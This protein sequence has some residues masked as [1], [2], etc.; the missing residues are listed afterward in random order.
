MPWRWQSRPSP[1][2]REAINPVRHH[3]RYHLGYISLHRAELVIERLQ[4]AAE[5]LALARARLG[6]RLRGVS[7]GRVADVSW[8]RLV[9]RRRPAPSGPTRAS[10]PTG[11]GP[12]HFRDALAPLCPACRIARQPLPLRPERERAGRRGRRRAVPP[13]PLLGL[14]GLFTPRGVKRRRYTPPESLGLSPASESR[15]ARANQA[16]ALTPSF[17]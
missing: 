13:L 9:P 10:V 15:L 2:S 4:Q 14:L 5:Q 8:T 12:R 3:L 7:R 16:G 1:R 17:E 11:K 6:K